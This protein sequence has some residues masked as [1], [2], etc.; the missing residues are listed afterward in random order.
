MKST[1]SWFL[2]GF[3]CKGS[4]ISL[5]RGQ[6]TFSVK[7][8]IINVIGAYRGPYEVLCVARTQGYHCRAKATIVD[9]QANGVG[10]VPI[11]LYLKKQVK[12]WIWPLGCSCGF[13]V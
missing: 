7:N 10:C 11:K 3:D 8:Q 4:V 12:G 1:S 6:Q 5:G 2:Q 13:L 9:T